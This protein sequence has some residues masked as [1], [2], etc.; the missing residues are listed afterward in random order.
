[1]FLFDDTMD[2][3]DNFFELF[4]IIKQQAAT[5]KK[6]A[7]IIKKQAATIKKFEI[8]I[9]FLLAENT[10][11]KRRLGLNSSTSSKP[12]SSDGLRKKPT[13]TS[14]RTKTGRS[15]GGQKGHKGSTLKQVSNPDK[16]IIHRANRCH[17]CGLDLTDTKVSSCIKKQV[18]DIPQPHFFVCEH[19]AEIKH[20][21]CG[22]KVVGKFPTHINSPVLYGEN[23]KSFVN[24]FQQQQL[25]PVNRVSSILSDVF[26]IKVAE[27]SLIKMG[28]DFAKH[29][30]SWF[31]QNRTQILEAPV[32]HLDETG[33]RVNGKT[34]WLQVLSSKEGTC[35]AVGEKRGDIF[36]P[37]HGVVVHD[38]FKPYQKLENVDHALCNA[39]HL[40]ELKALIEIEKEPWAAAMKRLLLEVFV[41]RNHPIEWVKSHYDT[42]INFGLRYHESQK[43]LKTGARGRKKRR[44]GHNLLMR[45]QK[46]KDDVLRFYTNLDVP[47]TNNLAEQDI[48]MMKCKQKIS[49]SFRT[50]QGAR[51]FC[52]IRS[53]ISTCRKCR[54]NIIDAI[55]HVSQGKNAQM[56]FN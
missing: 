32:K 54:L 56:L 36:K 18:F 34:Y 21:C 13:P 33:F 24:Y 15:S 26:G 27:S 10:A 29:L 49:G 11:L 31:E 22:E 53:F 20:C 8:T 30:S 12:P 28:N 45:F 1:M 43:P 55:K 42:I 52:T 7:A 48:R 16:I 23:I 14:L 39:H 44:I 3:K 50:F 5:I 35:Y 2:A 9:N 46:F 47:F 25:I 37:K 6:Q 38:G 17:K 19:Q 40:R 4:A 41:D 51:V